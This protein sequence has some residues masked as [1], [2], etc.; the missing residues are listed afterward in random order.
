MESCSRKA[1]IKQPAPYYRNTVKYEGVVAGHGEFA[2]A[3]VCLS[4]VKDINIYK[5]RVRLNAEFA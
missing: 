2:A 4:A 3:N 5:S 1:K